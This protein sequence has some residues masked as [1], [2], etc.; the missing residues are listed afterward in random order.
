MRMTSAVPERVLVMGDD[1]RI[2]LSVARS[3]GRAGKEVHAAPFNWNAPALKSRYIS[4]IHHLPR[5]SD[6]PLAWRDAV[7][8]LV[9]EYS[10][11]LIVPCHDAAI[12]PLDAHRND[13]TECALA[14]PDRDQMDLL[15][16]KARTRQMCAE[17]SIPIAPGAQLETIE[18]KGYLAEMFG[19]PLVI[20]P[21]R[22]YSID[23]LDELRKVAIVRDAGDLQKALQ[24][25]DDPERW[26]VESRFE[27]DG[28][29]VSVL[30]SSGDILQAFQHRR[31]RE[32]LGGPSSYRISE[33]VH[34]ELLEA[35]KKIA[36]HTRLTG[37]CM[38]EFRF[39]AESRKWILLETNARFW[40]S[41]PL[42][43]SLG[44][45]FPRHLYDL[46]VHGR[47][48]PPDKYRAGVRGRNLML[49]G[50]TLL[51]GLRA[52]RSG[53]FM[54]EL[55]ETGRFMMQPIGWITGREKSDSFAVDDLWP[56]ILECTTLLRTLRERSD[57]LNNAQPL[58]RAG[59][60]GKQ[61]PGSSGLSFRRT[62]EVRPGSTIRLTRGGFLPADRCVD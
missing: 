46:L 8:G 38:F 47:K 41:L 34:P 28:V 56:S 59:D 7:Q 6:G 49:D 10:F 58:R 62:D 61:S 32:R 54:N 39:N 12:L 29:G 18:R 11:R 22:S 19:L 2:F 14:I 30:A 42:P 36:A 21:R 13:L 9:E 35:C 16:D 57:R 44:V 48:N 55:A 5:Y 27:G 15:F 37:V 43:V 4:K 25:V 33:E 40:G 51:A 60:R 20:K 17:L 45:D 23:S 31:L 3:L 50:L 1:M 52:A 26:L 24:A 53:R